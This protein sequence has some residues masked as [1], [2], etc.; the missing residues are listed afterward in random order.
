MALVV[1]Q[2]RLLLERRLT[3]KRWQSFQW[4][5]ARS[6]E[7]TRDFLEPALKS[8][9][10]L[11]SITERAKLGNANSRRIYKPMLQPRSRQGILT[12]S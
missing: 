9:V 11:M 5:V 10:L 2:S 6:Y 1:F 3:P 4:L 12:S 7:F 8:N